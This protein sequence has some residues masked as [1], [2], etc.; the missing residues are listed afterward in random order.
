QR[1]ARR[2]QD[3]GRPPAPPAGAP[4][5]LPQRGDAA[6]IA[7]EHG[8]VEVA[9]VDAELERIGRDDAEHLALAQTLLDRPATRRQIAAAIAAHDPAVARLVGD[10]AL[11]GR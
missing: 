9:D 6:G 1:R 4:G 8:D 7:G 10:A 2:H 11:D 5:L 3:R